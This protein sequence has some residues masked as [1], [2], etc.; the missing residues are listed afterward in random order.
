MAE[1]SNESTILWQSYTS[2]GSEREI[3]C[4]NTKVKCDI[5]N[6]KIRRAGKRDTNRISEEFLSQGQNINKRF[7]TLP[8][9]LLRVLG[10]RTSVW[11]PAALPYQAQ[12]ETLQY[13]Q[14]PRLH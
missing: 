9:Q 10:H 4:L 6:V 14:T 7:Y 2:K 13:R 12:E 5:H 8:L 11:P 1:W 3:T